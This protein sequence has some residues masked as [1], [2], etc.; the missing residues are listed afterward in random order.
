MGRH[1]LLILTG[2]VAS[3]VYSWED[4][5]VSE[6][7]ALI[8]TSNW[9]YDSVRMYQVKPT[10]SPWLTQPCFTIWLQPTEPWGRWNIPWKSAKLENLLRPRSL[11]IF[12]PQ[13]NHNLGVW[14]HFS[15]DDYDILW[16]CQLPTRTPFLALKPVFWLFDG[17]VEK[18]IEG[19]HDWWPP[20]Q[21]R[22]SKH[23]AEPEG[24]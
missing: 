17:S 20:Y 8:G 3:G 24:S 12:Q 4:D 1:E 19:E 11:E 22:K 21:T 6:V 9:P 18:I 13:D 10:T 15:R 2:G 16:L 23:R 14:Q 5:F 7:V